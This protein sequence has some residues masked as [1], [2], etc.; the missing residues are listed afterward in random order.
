MASE[1][2]RDEV[3][4][5]RGDDLRVRVPRSTRYQVKMTDGDD[6]GDADIA[7]RRGKKEG[8]EN[9]ASCDEV[10]SYVTFR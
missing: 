10:K 3:A 7:Y 4:G 2:G 9:R 5:L 1:S 8:G 6:A